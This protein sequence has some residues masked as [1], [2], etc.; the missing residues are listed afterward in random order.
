MSYY[1][2]KEKKNIELVEC[3]WYVIKWAAIILFFMWL[4]SKL[5]GK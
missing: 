5:I 4:G 1:E 2:E 3:W